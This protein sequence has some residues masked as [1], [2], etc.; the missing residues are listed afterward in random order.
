VYRLQVMNATESLQRYSVA[1][2]GLD[3][4]TVEARSATDLGPAESKW[5]A[6]SVQVPAEV[7][8]KLGPGA[9]KVEF[10]VRQMPNG[11]ASEEVVVRERTTFLVPR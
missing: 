2:T 10:E 1:V 3:G 11:G 7:A 4:A 9:H 8:Q 6:A 5:I